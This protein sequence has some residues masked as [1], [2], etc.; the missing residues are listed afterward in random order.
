MRKIKFLRKLFLLVLMEYG[1]ISL[2]LMHFVCKQS[3]I[4]DSVLR[5]LTQCFDMIEQMMTIHFH[6]TGCWSVKPSKKKS[7]Q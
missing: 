7:N 2:K 5:T 6:A 3:L 4:G 1:I